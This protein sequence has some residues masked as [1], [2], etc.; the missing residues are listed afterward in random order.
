MTA[1]EQIAII[2]ERARAMGMTYGQYIRKFSETTVSKA[3][4]NANYLEMICTRCR[5]WFRSSLKPSGQPYIT[6]PKCRQD[7]ARATE[8]FRKKHGLPEPKKATR[9]KCARCGEEIEV[10]DNR[11]KYCTTC[12]YAK[13]AEY[14]NEYRKQRKG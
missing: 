5:K 6:C 10:Q 14:Q 3:P 2:N 4:E 12:K 7:G 8:D 9:K 11:T 13:I 1:M